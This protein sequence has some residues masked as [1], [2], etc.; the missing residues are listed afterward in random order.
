M[1]GFV[2]CVVGEMADVQ[3]A[4]GDPKIVLASLLLALT[5]GV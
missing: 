2:V 5:T 1:V 4:Q 3:V